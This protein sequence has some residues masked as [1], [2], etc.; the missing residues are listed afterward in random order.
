M[1]KFFAREDKLRQTKE[2]TFSAYSTM[3]WVS[4]Y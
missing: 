1:V 4:V 2:D 3:V